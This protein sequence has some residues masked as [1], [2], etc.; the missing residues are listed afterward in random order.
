MWL[1]VW[2]FFYLDLWFLHCR[3]IKQTEFGRF[4]ATCTLL[5]AVK[6]A[7]RPNALLLQC[8]GC[9][10]RAS[11]MYCMPSLHIAA[12]HWQICELCSLELS[13]ETT[14]WS[15]CVWNGQHLTFSQKEIAGTGKRLTYTVHWYTG[16]SLF[17][18][19]NWLFK[20]QKWLCSSVARQ[21]LADCRCS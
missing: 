19:W 2:S 7:V 5:S 10:Y 1:Q 18:F 16:G 17:W 21:I 11:E 6:Y 4:C 8:S 12:F 20:R 9:R 3:D 15:F 14:T 13:V